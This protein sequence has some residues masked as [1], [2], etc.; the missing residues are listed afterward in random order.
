[1]FAKDRDIAKIRARTPGGSTRAS[2]I[3]RSIFGGIYFISFVVLEKARV[4]CENSFKS[5]LAVSDIEMRT[6]YQQWDGWFVQRIEAPE[7]DS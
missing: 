3:N 4:V 5:S 1:M 7:P 6:D 2:T